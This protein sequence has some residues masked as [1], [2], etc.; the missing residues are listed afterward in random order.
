MHGLTL[1]PMQVRLWF[2]A[3]P[4]YTPSLKPSDT[5]GKKVDHEPLQIRQAWDEQ[6][7]NGMPSRG[8]CFRLLKPFFKRARQGAMDASPCYREA[9]KLFDRATVRQGSN[10]SPQLRAAH[11]YVKAFMRSFPGN[12]TVKGTRGQVKATLL[13]YV[14]SM[15]MKLTACSSIQDDDAQKLAKSANGIMARVTG[16]VYHCPPDTPL[17]GDKLPHGWEMLTSLQE[18][19]VR[20]IV[21][22]VCFEQIGGIEVLIEW[23]KGLEDL[24]GRQQRLE[25]RM[26]VYRHNVLHFEE[27]G[28]ATTW[29]KKLNK[30]L[31]GQYANLEALTSLLKPALKDVKLL[32]TD[33]TISQMI[34]H[35]VNATLDAVQTVNKVLPQGKGLD[36]PEIPGLMVFLV[37]QGGC[38][39]IL[40]RGALAKC[41]MT[42]DFGGDFATFDLD[43]AG[44]YADTSNQ[45]VMDAEA[46]S[47]Q[48]LHTLRWIGDSC[49][50]ITE[51]GE[52]LVAAHQLK[53]HNDI[54]SPRKRVTSATPKSGSW[55][56]VKGRMH[57]DLLTEDEEDKEYEEKCLKLRQSSSFN[58]KENLAKQFGRPL[59]ETEAL[60][61]D[62]I[63]IEED[64]S[65]ETFGDGAGNPKLYVQADDVHLWE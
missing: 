59:H 14:R 63:L 32:S 41:F 30:Y 4:P 44:L 38:Q 31:P 61:V 51:G 16:E 50:V 28:H 29:A 23:A 20:Q 7:R 58:L 46:R 22:E 1:V 55:A 25:S 62:E 64:E 13:E 26:K 6:G 12:W 48:P 21:E 56:R 11:N 37:L 34:R 52:L 8:K 15:L 24:T 36:V 19:Q 9:A 3:E 47:I 10:A 27:I 45:F 57:G 5:S 43:P 53:E 42:D 65:R 39:D 54:V 18:Y 35:W 33:C 17:L 60:V 2:V 40:I 49:Q